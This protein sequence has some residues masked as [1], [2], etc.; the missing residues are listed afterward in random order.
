LQTLTPDE[1][2]TVK[3]DNSG[4][5]L[6]ELGNQGGLRRDGAT[7]KVV[8]LPLPD[9]RHHLVA[10]W[11]PAGR[12]YTAEAKPRSQQ[13]FDPAMVLLNDVVQ[14]WALPQPREAPKI[15][16][17]RHVRRGTR[18]G[19][20]LVHHGRARVTMIGLDTAKSVFQVH[21]VGE[22]GEVRDWGGKSRAQAAPERSRPLLR[23]AGNLHVVLEGCGAACHWARVPTGLGHEVKLIAPEAVRPFVKRDKKN[24]A[25]DAAA[26]CAATR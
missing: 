1:R 10:G 18:I 3:R 4:G 13:P 8:N 16:G 19:R 5:E 15:A 6:E 17:S 9:H 14:V 25:V 21:A 22:T 12:S 26:L 20:V 2:G 7:A 23:R 24:D 11:R